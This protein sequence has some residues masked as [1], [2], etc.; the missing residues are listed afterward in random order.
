MYNL[1]VGISYD[2]N[3]DKAIKIINDILKKDKRVLKD[4]APQIAVR[5]LGDNSVNLIVRPSMKKEDYWDVYFDTIKKIKEEFDKN[6]IG[7][8]FPQRDIWIKEMS[9]KKK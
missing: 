6:K 5:S 2:S 7:I 8:P 3:I 9:K 4:P 1:E